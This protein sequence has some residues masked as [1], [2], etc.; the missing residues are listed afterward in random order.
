MRKILAISLLVFALVPA[1]AAPASATRPDQVI[2]LP[3]ASSTE[4]VAA[5][6][7]TTFFAGDLFRGDIFRGDIRRGTAELFIDAPD[8]RLAVGMATDLRHDLLFVAGGPGRAYVYDTRTGAAVASYDLADPATS[9]VNDVA[10]TPFGAWFTDSLR[11]QLYFV[12]LRHGVPGPARTLALS[13]PAADLSGEFNLN[14]IRATPSG[15]TLI[16][17]HST[18]GALMTVNPVTGSSSLIAGADVPGADGLVLSGRRMWVAH[19]NQITRLTLAP[20]LTSATVDKVI[21]SPHF[22]VP[23]TAALFGNRLAAANSHFDTGI[24]PTSPTYEVVVVDA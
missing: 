12:P 7:G 15:R 20:D 11:A 6:R 4:G 2:L 23:T 10:V 16:V 17:A 13:G 1:M 5:G 19:G 22:A 3:G 18:L 9:F 14:G 24:P 21:T 8:G